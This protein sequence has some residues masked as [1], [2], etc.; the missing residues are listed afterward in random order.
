MVEI[1]PEYILKLIRCSILAPIS[2]TEIAFL[3]FGHPLSVA[4]EDHWMTPYTP[5]GVE[6]YNVVTKKLTNVADT[7]GFAFVSQ[8]ST[9]RMIKKG[10]IAA[11]VLD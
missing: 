10:K 4:K 9:C 1:G 11:I 3:R 8:V 7:A 5:G 6:I 2:D